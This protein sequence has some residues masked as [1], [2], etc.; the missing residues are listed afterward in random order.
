MAEKVSFATT[1]LHQAMSHID[2]AANFIFLANVCVDDKAATQEYL[3]CAGECL[4]EA[5]SC[6]RTYAASTSNH[7]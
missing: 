1:T 4:A 2:V 5:C 6:V 3:K 7:R